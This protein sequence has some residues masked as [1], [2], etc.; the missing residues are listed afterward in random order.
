MKFYGSC[1]LTGWNWTRDRNDC[2]ATTTPRDV[3]RI[4]WRLALHVDVLPRS[5]EIVLLFNLTKKMSCWAIFSDFIVMLQKARSFSFMR[6]N[7]KSPISRSTKVFNHNCKAYSWLTRIKT[8]INFIGGRHSTE[9]AFGFSPSSPWF[10]SQRS[11]EFFWLFFLT[12]YFWWSTHSWC[13]WD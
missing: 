2:Y 13:C 9:V 12:N 8:N 7:S 6:C 10:D 5:I 11:Q 3:L 1:K 4:S